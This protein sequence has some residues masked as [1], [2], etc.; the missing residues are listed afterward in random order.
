MTEAVADGHAESPRFSQAGG[1]KPPASA[2]PLAAGASCPT[3]QALA[4]V[5]L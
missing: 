3:G 4:H 5:S 2:R 1:P